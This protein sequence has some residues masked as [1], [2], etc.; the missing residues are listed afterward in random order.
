MNQLVSAIEE[1]FP[2]IEWG[3]RP[4]TI[5]A[6]AEDIEDTERVFG[7][8][9]WTS[10][11]TVALRESIDTMLLLT[12]EARVFYL[13]AFACLLARDTEQTWD[14][15]YDYFL[16]TLTPYDG[17]FAA[18]REIWE[19]VEL[20]E[21]CQKRA[22]MAVQ[23]QIDMDLEGAEIPEDIKRMDYWKKWMASK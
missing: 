12:P 19:R 20:L 2:S 8:R 4:L 13:P 6:R 7:R 22:L 15:L 14:V 18:L 11:D 21:P 1:A 10:I 16:G 17:P 9:P 3:D 5:S 23:E